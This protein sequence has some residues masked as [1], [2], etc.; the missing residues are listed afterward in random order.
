MALDL[1]A[2]DPEV[3]SETLG[4]PLSQRRSSATTGAPGWSTKEASTGP[5]SSPAA[6]LIAAT[7]S[8]VAALACGWASRYP[9]TPFWNESGPIQASIIASTDAP[10]S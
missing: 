6:S 3:V 10:L 4:V 7:K 5:M 9:L 8:A 2:L 1:T